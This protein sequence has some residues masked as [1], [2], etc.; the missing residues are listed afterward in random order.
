LRRR[1]KELAKTFSWNLPPRA[2]L[3]HPGAG[4]RRHPASKPAA[5]FNLSGVRKNKN[6]GARRG[7]SA[8]GYR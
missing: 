2:R 3:R 6:A 8:A 1:A 7:R 5:A 4:I